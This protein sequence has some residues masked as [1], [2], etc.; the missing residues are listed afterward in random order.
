MPK[1]MMVSDGPGAGNPRLP[2][3]ELTWRVS[4]P[5]RWAWIRLCGTQPRALGQCGRVVM[6]TSPPDCLSCDH[7]KHGGQPFLPIPDA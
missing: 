3:A 4:T 5:G 7:Q 1:V 6:N 2:A